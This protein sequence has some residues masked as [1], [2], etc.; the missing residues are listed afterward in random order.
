MKED[1]VRRALA[2]FLSP[3]VESPDAALGKK[4]FAI[5]ATAHHF[6]LFHGPFKGKKSGPLAAKGR[7]AVGGGQRSRGAGRGFARP[8]R[9]RPN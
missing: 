5:C 6:D 4:P 1:K 7:E 3:H 2:A 9:A 8:E